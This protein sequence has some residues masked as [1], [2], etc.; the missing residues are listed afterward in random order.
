MTISSN[1]SFASHNERY[2][3]CVHYKRSSNPASTAPPYPINSM[4]R[5]SKIFD[6]QISETCPDNKAKMNQPTN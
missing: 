3:F 4:Q 5:F 6:D 1:P 2:V